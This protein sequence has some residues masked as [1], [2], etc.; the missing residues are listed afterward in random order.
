MRK[1]PLREPD[2]FPLH[3]ALPKFHWQPFLP[4]L[5]L[6]ILRIEVGVELIWLWIAHQLWQCGAFRQKF[7]LKFGYKESFQEVK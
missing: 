3:L 7:Q 4:W 1:V 5:Y 2:Y 6:D